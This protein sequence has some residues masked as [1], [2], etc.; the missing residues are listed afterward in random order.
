M[1]S[2]YAHSEENHLSFFF[3]Q[4]MHFLVTAWFFH[5]WNCNMACGLKSHFC[6]CATL[7][8]QAKSVLSHVSTVF[9]FTLFNTEFAMFFWTTTT[10]NKHKNKKREKGKD[11]LELA[12]ALSF[13][14]VGDEI[15]IWS[16]FCCRPCL[17]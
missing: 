7:Q 10:T 14:N 17:E 13:L 2:Q 12:D 9:S 15:R 16:Y 4:Y 8:S 6:T 1:R 3:F 11:L 5:L